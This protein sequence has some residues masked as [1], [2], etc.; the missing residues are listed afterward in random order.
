MKCDETVLKSLQ[1]SALGSVL[2]DRHLENVGQIATEVHE[3]AGAVLF[4][5]G[6]PA[7]ALWL[8]DSG[9]VALDMQVPLRGAVRILTLGPR[10]LLGWSSMVGDGTM[11]TTATVMENTGLLRIPAD[12]LKDLC[13][14]DHSL[15]FAVMGFVA[16]AVANRLRGARLQLLD[17]YAE[18]EPSTSQEM[19]E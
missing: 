6:S 9:Q 18:T 19:S 5:E 16:R 3:S 1:E 4:K 14:S 12:K 15:G 11:S 2:D 10:D 17:L 7:S 8:I 13:I